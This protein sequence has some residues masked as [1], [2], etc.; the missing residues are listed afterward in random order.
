M[1]TCSLDSLPTVSVG[2]P[3]FNGADF[4]ADAIESVLN[5]AFDDLELIICDNAST[6]RTAEICREYASRDRRVRYFHNDCNLGAVPNFNRAVARARG[7]YFKWLAHD[8]RLAPNYLAAT[9]AALEARP[10]AALCN[11]VVDYINASG[12]RIAV[13]QTGLSA[14]DRAEPGLR[15]AAMILCSHSCVDFFGLIR[16][17]AMPGE[18]RPFHGTDRA[19]L[20]HLALRGRLVQL[21]EPLVEMREYGGR[22]TRRCATASARLT[23]HDA[24]LRGRLTFPTWRLFAAYLGMVHSERLPPGQRAICWSAL[25]QWWV[26]NWNA[27][28]AGVDLIEAFAPGA[29]VL[30]EQMKARMFGLA[31]GH[32]RD[33]NLTPGS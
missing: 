27:A 18:L 6:D 2:I 25:G 14:A 21:A 29:V 15:F 10:D 12:D 19:F 31:P 24:S 16:R 7:P 17:A 33:G 28:R 22:Y 4:L 20:A 30:A 3:V 1:R 5:Q 32:F 11:T 13:Y 23:W 9:V 26:R 8:D